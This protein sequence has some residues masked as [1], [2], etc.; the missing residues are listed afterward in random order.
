M[1]DFTAI[2]TNK[3]ARIA[4]YDIFYTIGEGQSAKVKLARHRLTRALVAI[5]IVEKTEQPNLRQ[6]FREVRALRSVNKHRNIVQLVEIIDTEETLFLIMEHLSGGDLATYLEA[7][8][9]LTE[10]EARG[11]FRQLVSALRHCHRRGVV[12]RD[13]KPGNILL[14]ASKIKLADFGLSGQWHPGRKLNT[15]CGTPVYMAPE[16]FLRLPYTGPEVDVWSLG[17]VLYT[18]VTGSVPFTGRDFREVRDCIRT[19]HYHVPEDL[20]GEV[21]DLIRRMLRLNP[22]NRATLDDVRHHPWLN[23]GL[24]SPLPPAYGDY[25]G[26]TMGMTLG[27]SRDQIQGRHTSTGRDWTVPKVRARTIFVRPAVSLDL[28]S[29]EHTPPASPEVSTL[30]PGW[31]WEAT[32][33]ENQESREKTR[34]PATPSPCPEAR[35]ITPSSA[36]STR[37]TREERSA[38]A[39]D[40]A[41]DRHD[42]CGA[43]LACDACGGRDSS[44]T[45]DTSFT[46]DTRDACGTSL[47]HDAPSTQDATGACDREDARGA[48][49]PR[50]TRG[51]R[52]T[53]LTC[54]TSLPHDAPSTQDATG[55]CHTE[56]ARGARVP[57][58]TR[59]A[60]DTSLTCD[61]SLPHDAP[62]TQ[63]ATGA[64]HTEDARGAR[65][66]RD[67]RGARD[68]GGAHGTQDPHAT[69]TRDARGTCDVSSETHC[70]PDV[71]A[72]GSSTLAGQPQNL[73]PV[74]PPGLTQK[75]KG[76]AGRIWRGLLKHLCCG[77]PSK[78][79]KKV[80]PE[81]PRG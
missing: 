6:L 30:I 25:P 65:V 48:R 53:G 36:P 31:L 29:E 27:W 55:A 26:V 4:D 10:E 19:G 51:A 11:V 66:P 44:H 9:Y 20:S 1:Q 56:D 47:P 2:S 17:V 42:T 80:S 24:E 21:K 57:R 60:R 37:S 32:E 78:R 46:R 13:V 35:T 45:R 22:A 18:L 69:V 54:D 81:T 77:L 63:D 52:D 12:H 34:E 62:S 50:D 71:P 74:T 68:T 38:P 16:L 7:Q 72:A 70:P 75:K 14:E 40:R 3:M 43:R 5:K 79:G 73:S 8:G 23:V 61:T 39:T 33:Q 15:F 64:C 49:V 76:V 41:G 58:D 67:T 28:S 59:D